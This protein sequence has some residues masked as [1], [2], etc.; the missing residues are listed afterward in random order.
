M[1]TITLAD[2][3]SW[4]Y[5]LELEK[6]S[7]SKQTDWSVCTP[8]MIAYCIRDVEVTKKLYEFLKG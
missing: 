1:T 6:D 8:E 5:R 7:F 4:G 3:L 2:A